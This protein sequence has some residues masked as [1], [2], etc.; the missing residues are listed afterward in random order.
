MFLKKYSK[1]H[2]IVI[3]DYSG[4]KFLLQGRKNLKSGE[5]VFKNTRLNSLFNLMQV[6]N[7]D[8]FNIKEQFN[9]ILNEQ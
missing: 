7:I 8:I 5:L 1:W 6:E 3:Y 2:P 4:N 9:K